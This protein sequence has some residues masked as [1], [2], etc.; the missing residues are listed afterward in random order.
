[1]SILSGKVNLRDNKKLEALR[2]RFSITKEQGTSIS[3]FIKSSFDKRKTKGRLL[4]VDDEKELVRLLK[5]TLEDEGFQVITAFDVESAYQELKQSAVDLILCDIKF[6]EG[7]LDGF[8]FHSE[9]QEYPHLR[10]IPFIFMSALRD[11]VI[12]RSGFQL[13]VDD[14]LTKP[15]DMEILIAIINGKLK[16]Y[17]SLKLI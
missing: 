2:K 5:D 17:R 3:S 13:G 4:I 16:R 14:Y 8:K 10:K 7:D 1:M 15:L 11:G 6:P 9:I 12:M